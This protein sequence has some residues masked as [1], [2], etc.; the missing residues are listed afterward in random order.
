M[1]TNQLIPNSPN[2]IPNNASKAAIAR[3]N[4]IKFE[5]WR[6]G[7][8]PTFQGISR[9]MEMEGLRPYAST[10]GPNARIP[11]R[12]HTYAKVMY[13]VSGSLELFFPDTGQSLTMRPG[14]RVELPG[15]VRHATLIGS[16]GAQCLEAPR[17]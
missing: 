5:R 13:C 3:I 8:H 10:N 12:S 2:Y 6:G 7:Q 17:Q 16:Q 15:G 1:G 9:K 14:D 11:A 4:E